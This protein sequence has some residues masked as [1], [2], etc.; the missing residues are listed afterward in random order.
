MK[1]ASQD[2]PY[3]N[4]N[5]SPKRLKVTTSSETESCQ[6]STTKWD[7]RLSEASWDPLWTQETCAIIFLTMHVVVHNDKTTM[8]DLEKT[9]LQVSM[10]ATDCD[11]L[12]VDDISKD[13]PNI[14]I[15]KF[16]CVVFQFSV[17][18]FLLNATLCHHLKKYLTC[19]PLITQSIT[20][21]QL[22]DSGC[23]HRRGRL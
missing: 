23:Q 5:S 3:S 1:G 18:L 7:Y 21:H 2:P 9:F 17:C 22:C 8:A 6:L 16:T 4:Y 20:V 11:M 13:S 14:C 10:T 19:H 15:L 12:W